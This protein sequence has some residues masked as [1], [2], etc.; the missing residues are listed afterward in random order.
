MDWVFKHIKK[1]LRLYQPWALTGAV[2][3]GGGSSV[4]TIPGTAT[5]S[6]AA[7][8]M[9]SRGVSALLVT[10]GTGR[11]AG[12]FTERDACVVDRA[13]RWVLWLAGSR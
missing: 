7:A 10:G 8:L 11:L 6:E 12:I 1:T 9:T 13:L 5:V 2:G 3:H 4:C